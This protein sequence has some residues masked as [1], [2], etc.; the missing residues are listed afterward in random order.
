V[1]GEPF[2]ERHR[3]LVQVALALAALVVAAAGFL[4]FRRRV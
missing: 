4:A 1:P 3:W 2:G